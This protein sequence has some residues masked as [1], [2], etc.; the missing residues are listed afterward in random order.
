MLKLLSF[1]F[2][3]IVPL[4]IL[5][6]GYL[7]YQYLMATGPEPERRPPVDRTPVVE[8]QQ[9]D[10]QDYTAVIDASGV[11]KAR[12][13][14]SLVTEVAGRVLEISP[15][16]R[17]GGYVSDSE[18]LVRLDDT[19]YQDAIRIAKA[20]IL[21]NEAALEQLD[22]EERN[23]YANMQLARTSLETVQKNLQVAQANMNNVRRKQAPIQ[24]NADLIRRN[25]NL[26]RQNMDITRKNLELAKRDLGSLSQEDMRLAR[27]DLE[28]ARRNLGLAQKEM[29]R[30]RELGQ[31]RLI[32]LNQVDAQ[33]QVVLQQQQSVSQKQLA[34]SQKQQ[35]VSQ[36]QQQI[37][38][39]E[40]SLVQQQQALVQQEQQLAQQDTSEAS[41]DQS[42]LSQQQSILQQE[43]A[44]N[45]Q[46][47][48]V[49]SLRGQLATFASR[50]KSLQASNDLTR[51]QLLQQ[52]RNL[53]RTEIRAPYAGRVLEQ[54]VDVGQYLSPNANLGVLYAIDYVEVDL[55]LTLEQYALLDIPEAFRGDTPDLSQF[56]K[57]EFR[58][59]FGKGP[60][61]SGR[62]TGT[63][64]SL[65]EQSRQINVVAR[66]DNPYER[67]ES[68]PDTALKIGQYLNARI[69]GR[70]FSEVYVL[71]PIA[72][73]Q[74][75]ETL[76]MRDGR[77]A[78]V[79]LEVVWG[80]ETEMVSRTEQPLDAPV[81]V[82]ALGQATEG[83]RVSLPGQKPDGGQGGRPGAGASGPRETGRQPAGPVPDAEQASLR[84]V[85]PESTDEA[86]VDT[87]TDTNPAG[88]DAAVRARTGQPDAAASREN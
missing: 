48:N 70:T 79:P 11:V 75:R 72:V 69:E 47:Q 81:I 29:N 10:L 51:T 8:V 88:P 30:I 74:N 58:L 15:N 22:Q 66:I 6:G 2:K 54:H 27:S 17:P 85:T 55:P 53:E 34:I 5:A 26:V 82:T 87:G 63:R 59:P 80:T 35:S 78:I 12:T 67:T 77:V 20:N 44:V 38:Q 23:V 31:R 28:L 1:L 36:K 64:A 21:A 50:R 3:T 37:L 84:D 14:T 9:V 32:P 61:W 7:G 41:Q 24:K 19:N 68:G 73:R 42:V 65:N 46:Q 16:F 83:M 39:L 57:V 49:T 33:E 62:I 45:Q 13:Q 56:P 25:L 43:Q 60:T 52:Q 40:Q 4:V 18:V 71:P 76:L 86:G